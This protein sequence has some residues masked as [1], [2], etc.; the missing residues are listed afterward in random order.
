MELHQDLKKSSEYPNSDLKPIHYSAN[1]VRSAHSIIRRT[2]YLETLIHL[3]KACVCSGTFA[4]GDAMKNAGLVFGPIG[5]AT[6]GSICIY[7]NHMLVRSSIEIR[8]R[9]KLSHEPN[10]PETVELCFEYGPL[11]LR[12]WRNFIRHTVKTFIIATQLG[13]CSVYFVFVA[14]TLQTILDGYGYKYDPRIYISMALLPILLS[15]LIRSLKLLTPLS[16]LSNILILSGICMAAYICCID[17]PSISERRL[18]ADY[19]NWPLFLGTTIYA[20]EG[21]S[22]VIPLRNEMKDPKQFTSPFGVLNVGLMIVVSLAVCMGFLSYLKY[23]DEVKGSFTLNLDQGIFTVVIMSTVAL[24]ILLTYPI[25]FHVAVDLIWWDLV[26]T[27]GPFTHMTR[28]E[29]LLRMVVV[30]IT[31]IMAVVVPQLNLFISL[32]G[33]MCSTTLALV[34][35]ALCDI[36]LRS[37]PVEDSRSRPSSTLILR[38]TMDAI[39]LILAVVACLTGTFYSSKNIIEVFWLGKNLEQ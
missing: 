33:A 9:L 12:K 27:R 28:Y 36:S 2:S 22:I 35:P 17:L 37:C 20:F 31:Y 34:L 6:L 26:A 3:L 5:I 29:M 21:I 38:Y 18:I 4:M 15:S 16:L 39:S 32:I 1:S 24:G 23:G 13:F 7:N 10:F 25:Q 14:S 30:L 8:K 11:V 19:S